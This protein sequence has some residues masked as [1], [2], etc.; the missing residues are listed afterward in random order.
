MTWLPH[1]E[2]WAVVKELDMH[3]PFGLYE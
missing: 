2:T 1:L 3:S